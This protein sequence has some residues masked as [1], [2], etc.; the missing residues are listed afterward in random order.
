MHQTSNYSLMAN[1]DSYSYS[2][3]K[4]LLSLWMKDFIMKNEYYHIFFKEL[5]HP[6]L[7]TTLS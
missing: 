4:I 7:D 3:K 6:V 1:E 2:L 5:S